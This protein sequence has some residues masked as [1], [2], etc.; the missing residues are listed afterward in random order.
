MDIKELLHKK[1]ELTE[2]E[3]DALDEYYTVNT[4]LPAGGRAGYFARHYGMPVY[5]DMETL[6]R[7][8]TLAG[9]TRTPPADLIRQ[10]VRD[11]VSALA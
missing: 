9:N 8:D 2:A 3:Y 11:R 10:L 6:E 4:I 5:L 7:L 1:G